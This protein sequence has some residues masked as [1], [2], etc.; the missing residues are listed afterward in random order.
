MA[1][2]SMSSVLPRKLNKAQT[3]KTQN[4]MWNLKEQTFAR[5]L[6]KNKYDICKQELSLKIPHAL[7]KKQKN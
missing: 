1:N 4:T 7:F 3:N 6:K 5:V 2:E